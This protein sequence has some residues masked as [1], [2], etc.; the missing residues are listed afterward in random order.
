MVIRVSLMACKRRILSEILR[1][2]WI[3]AVES[4]K[5][6]KKRS[7]IVCLYDPPKSALTIPFVEHC[8]SWRVVAM[9]I[10]LSRPCHTLGVCKANAKMKMRL[11]LMSLYDPLRSAFVIPVACLHVVLHVAPCQT[12]GRKSL[13][14]ECACI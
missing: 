8:A 7:M 2:T 10:G 13:C 9:N 11:I 1:A 14:K 4:L 5:L 3:V 6:N 12:F